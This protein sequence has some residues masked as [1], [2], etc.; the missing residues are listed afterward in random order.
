M[1]VQ[2]VGVPAPNLLGPGQGRSAGAPKGP[3]FAEFLSRA[4]AEVNRIQLEADQ[5][6][7]R[8]VYGEVED[9]HQVM[10][11]TEKANLALELTIQVRNKLLEAYQEIMRMQV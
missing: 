7:Q 4:L 11:L 5:A 2:A 10:I 9:L 6:S 8:L 1:K 3:E